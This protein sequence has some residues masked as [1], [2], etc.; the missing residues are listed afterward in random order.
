MLSFAL[1]MD[2]FTA[3]NLHDEAISLST[4]FYFYVF[5]L[6]FC[7]ASDYKPSKTQKYSILIGVSL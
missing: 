5:A 1:N 7:K 4:T 6:C 3:E 2:C